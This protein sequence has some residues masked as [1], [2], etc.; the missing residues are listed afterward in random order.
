[1]RPNQLP[2][3]HRVQRRLARV[4]AVTLALELVAAAVLILFR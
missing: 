2:S 1:M 4:V 3:E